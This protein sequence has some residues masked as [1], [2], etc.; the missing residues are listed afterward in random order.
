[1]LCGGVLQGAVPT[2][3]SK[4]ALEDCNQYNVSWLIHNMF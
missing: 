1:V 2:C 3:V 4:T